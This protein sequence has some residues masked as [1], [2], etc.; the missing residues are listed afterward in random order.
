MSTA[1]PARAHLFGVDIDAVTMD[2]TVDMVMRCID[3]G[4][5]V[6]HVVLNAAKIVAMSKDA[7]LREVIAA[8]P[9]VNADG[10]SVVVASRLLRQPLPERVAG[11]DLFVRLVERAAD[12]GH[13]VYF[14]GARD[15]VLDAMVR[16]F[17]TQYPTLDIAGYRNGYW[18]DDDEVVAEVCRSKADLLFLAIPSPRKEFWL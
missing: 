7:A 16:K 10:M 11:I 5:Q 1:N 13:R 4:Q 3:D 6:Q 2:E 12:T 17:R 15:E 14:L 18:T 8:C 9:I